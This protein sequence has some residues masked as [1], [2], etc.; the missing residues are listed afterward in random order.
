MATN[1]NWCTPSRT[2]S[3]IFANIQAVQ[4]CGLDWHRD[5]LRLNASC[6]HKILYYDLATHNTG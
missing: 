6:L 1:G 3:S 2:T 4:D 5:L